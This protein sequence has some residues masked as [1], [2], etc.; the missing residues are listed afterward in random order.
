MQNNGEVSTLS[1]SHHSRYCHRQ[2]LNLLI[3]TR[4]L[5]IPEHSE[6]TD[7]CNHRYRTP[8]HQ[9]GYP[10]PRPISNRQYLEHSLRGKAR[11]D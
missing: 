3:R 2:S 9:P 11:Q 7:G 4:P 10:T 8:D 6:G 1:K 5:D